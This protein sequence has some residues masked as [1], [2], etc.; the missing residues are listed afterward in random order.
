MRKAEN[1]VAYAEAIARDNSHGYD[2]VDRWGNPNFD[3]SGLVIT[4]LEQAGIPAKT[5]GATYTGN[6]LGACKKAGMQDVTASINLKTGAGLLR[7]DVL[8]NKTHHTA[9][10]CGNGQIVDARINENGKAT[11]G[12]SG[13]QTG[14]EIMVHAYYNYPWTN[15]LR[16]VEDATET[17]TS[18]ISSEIYVVKAGDTLSGIAKQYGTTTKALQELNRIADANKI[19]VGQKLQLT[20][21]ANPAVKTLHVKT[22]TGAPLNLRNTAGGAII[23][24]MPN[25]S[26]VTTDGTTNGDW[27][28]VQYKGTEGWASASRIK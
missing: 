18:S 24:A 13:D 19:R 22:N 6:M 27:L 15:V 11:G 20:G 2:Q 7:G 1:A 12:K 23:L 25:G 26:A 9:F 17:I 8:L 10:Y 16:Y 4:A 3:C 21:S 5:K 14:K 28:K